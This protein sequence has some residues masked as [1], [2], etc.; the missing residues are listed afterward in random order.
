M[1]SL[2]ESIQ[3]VK[4]REPRSETELHR[5]A[6][7]NVSE[8]RLRGAVRDVGGKLGEC[9]FIGGKGRER[10]NREGSGGQCQG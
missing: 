2:R 6:E 4:G 5:M 1:R 10:S 7:E 3:Q 8:R 9:G